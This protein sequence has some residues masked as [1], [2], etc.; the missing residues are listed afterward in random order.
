MKRKLKLIALSLALLCANLAFAQKQTGSLKGTVTDR[1]TGES[2]HFGQVVLKVNDTVIDGTVADMDG[3]YIINKILPGI[4]QLEVTFHGYSKVLLKD[5]EIKA[6]QSVRRD[7]AL[8]ASSEMLQEVVIQSRAPLIDKTKTS[9]KISRVEINALTTRDVK[10]RG[11]RSE[12]VAYFLNGIKVRDGELNTE[13]YDEIS[14]N[15]FFE[16]QTVP[17]STFSSDVD[18]ASYANVRRFISNGQLPP[19]DAVRIE[20][21]INYFDYDYPNPKKGKTFSVTTEMRACPWIEQHQ[22]LRIG[23]QT[24]KID[25]KDMPPSNLVFLLDVSGSMHSENKLPLLKKALRLLVNNLRAKD[26][27]S[28]VVYAGASGLVLPATS[29]KKKE[30]ILNA[31]EALNSGGST[32]GAE[33]IELAYKTAKESFIKKGINRVILATD[34]DFNV[35]ISGDEQ[36]TKLIETKREEGVSLSVLGFG[37]GNYKDSKMEKLADNGNGNY[38]YIDNLFEAKKILVTEM[39]STL[40]TVAK[41]TKFQVEFNPQ[42]VQAY[43]LVGYENRLLN[44]EDFNDDTKDAG[45]VGAGHSVTAVYEIVPKGVKMDEDEL[46]SKNIDP[47]KYQRLDPISRDENSGEVATVKIRHKKAGEKKSTLETHVVKNELGVVSEDFKFVSSVI[48]FGLL[49][50]DSEFKG[51]SSIVQAVAMASAGKG[52]DEKGYRAEFIRMMEM[53]AEL[54]SELAD[55]NR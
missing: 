54:D 3:K 49:L 37:M 10:I 29:G 20:E 31:I 16:A 42:R 50:R 14:E 28:I 12:G 51:N 7:F 6:G 15:R 4:Y 46:K 9:A 5:L 43:R 45:D 53:A 39:G 48:E 26:R 32:A 38:A 24:Q 13:Q 30:V 27:V 34:G 40:Q 25:L 22:L 44:D 17:L 35:G 21:M 36:L 33:G 52:E 11:S 2:V 41:D 18:A 8:K 1:E 19:K 55:M 23:I 47:L